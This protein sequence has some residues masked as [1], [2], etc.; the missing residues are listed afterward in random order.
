MEMLLVPTM[1]QA[2]DEGENSTLDPVRHFSKLHELLCNVSVTSR[3]GVQSTPVLGVGQA[4]EIVIAAHSAAKKII[5]VGNGGSAAIASHLAL[6][7]WNAC[8]IK[9]MTF[10]EAAQLT[11]LSN[12][13]GYENVFSRALGMFAEAGDVL[14]AISSSGRSRSI[15]N[16]AVDAGRMG[17]KVISFSGFSK[18]APLI[19][20]SDLNFY[21]DSDQYGCVEV[22]HMALTH[23]LTDVL[24]KTRN[25]VAK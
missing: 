9:A 13:Y 1:K 18:D 6:D 25:K 12:D 10:N 14:I 11:C 21:I 24:H 2:M 19:Y 4:I 17:L 16:A 5:V 15:V 20:T 8:G 22:A 7:L 3:G 23:Y